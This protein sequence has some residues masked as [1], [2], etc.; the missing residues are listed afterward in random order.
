MKKTIFI[1]ALVTMLFSMQSK[2]QRIIEPG[3]IFLNG[4]LGTTA[5]PYAG[6]DIGI[7]KNISVG[8]TAG[9]NFL[10]QRGIFILGKGNFHVN[11]IF[12]FEDEFDIYGGGT[13]GVL[14]HLFFA[15]HAGGRYEIDKKWDLHAEVSGGFFFEK[16]FGPYMYVQVGV[17]RKLF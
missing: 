12:D 7:K 3:N 17:S 11:E 13:V 4:G 10:Y 9:L 8:A 15:A 1:L 5:G 6:F 16:T 14:N 2:A